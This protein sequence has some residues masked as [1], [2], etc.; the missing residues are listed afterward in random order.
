MTGTLL[1]WTAPALLTAY[2]SAGLAA[3][4]VGVYDEST[5][6]ANAVDLLAPGSGT[7]IA[8]F[9]LDLAA[10]FAQNLGG[11]IDA[12]ALDTAYSYGASQAKTLNIN[13]LQFDSA[14]GTPATSPLPI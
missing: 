2:A 7:T 13:G 10:A 1:K 4:V 12:S 11:I 14:I 9:K 3:T 6:Q 8:Q 5:V